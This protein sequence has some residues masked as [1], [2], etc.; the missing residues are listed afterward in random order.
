MPAEIELKLALDPSAVRRVGRLSAVPAIAAARKGR[1]KTARLVS[2]YFDTAAGR[3]AQ[4]GIALRLRRAGTRWFQTI[5]GPPL[6]GAGAGLHARDEY[7]RRLARPRLDAAHLATTPWHKLLAKLLTRGELAA[8][9]VTDFTRRTLPL[10]FPDGTR[11]LLAIDIG[12]IRGLRSGV[13]RVPISEIEIEVETGN[14]ARAFEAALALVDD[15]PV[16]VATANKAER[17]YALIRGKPDGW[18]APVRARAVALAADALAETALRAVAQECLQQISAN[19]AGLLH[20]RDPE[21]VHQMRIGTRRLRSCLALIAPIAPGGQFDA[22]IAETKWLAGLLG[23]ARD[24]DVFAE[25]TLPPLAEGIADDPAAA[26]GVQ[27]L[28][29]RVVAR[30]RAARS[31]VQEALGSRRFQRLLL[32]LGALIAAPRFGA[33]E[34][35]SANGLVAPARAFAAHLLARRHH[36]L[37]GR[38]ASLAEGTA[39]ERHAVRIAAKKLRYAAEFFASLFAH[40]RTRIYLKRLGALQDALGRFNDAA[41]ATRLAALLAGA[42]DP[43]T[44]GAVGGWVAAQAATLR[45]ELDRAWQRF[46]DA[47]RFWT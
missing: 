19:T 1:V 18:D 40:K 31:T 2:T 4:E 22:A 20:D 9:F 26:P 12:A 45:P 38:A 37:L 5:K 6:A 8:Q 17:G 7:E 15:W 24:W 41:T 42:N 30:R 29:R 25:C 16:S 43:A 36:K 46:A 21:W 13:R 14:V 23:D 11:A 34:E 33:P 47:E 27:R 10:A 32:T 28:R 35:A 3:L 44:V 39:E